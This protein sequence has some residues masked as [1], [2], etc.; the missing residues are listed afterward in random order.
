MKTMLA[1]RLDVPIARLIRPPR[2][3]TAVFRAPAGYAGRRPGP[4]PP[5]GADRV[6]AAGDWVLYAAC[7]PGRALERVA[8][9]STIPL[10]R[11]ETAVRRAG[12]GSGS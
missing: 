11:P 1:W 12:A 7:A 10:P 9:R 4:A 2:P 5:P 3:P 8:D 6:A